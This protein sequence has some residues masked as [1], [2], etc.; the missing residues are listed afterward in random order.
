MTSPELKELADMIADNLV[1]RF[2][3]FHKDIL[4][5]PEAAMYLGVSEGYVRRLTSELAVRS[6]RPGGKMLYIERA[7]LDRY[8]RQ[9][10]IKSMADINAEALVYCQR[11]PR[12]KI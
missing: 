7:E 6:Y 10:P 12:R 3:V 9:N 8:M 4:S 1:P 11:N 5:I 2:A